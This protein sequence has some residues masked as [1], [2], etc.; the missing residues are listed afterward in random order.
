MPAADFLPW[1]QSWAAP[2]FWKCT[3][4]LQT[5]WLPLLYGM[6]ESRACVLVLEHYLQG[7]SSREP[8][9]DVRSCGF[10]RWVHDLK[11]AQ[12][13][14]MGFERQSPSW[15]SVLDLHEQLHTSI[16]ALVQ[17]CQTQGRSAALERL[18]HLWALRERLLLA[19]QDFL[20]Q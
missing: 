5:Q 2:A 12:L 1:L 4:T 3:P 16:A 13:Q 18:P 11:D 6:V 14:A 10:A 9:A 7:L 8:E 17:Q 19:L 15:L 20:P